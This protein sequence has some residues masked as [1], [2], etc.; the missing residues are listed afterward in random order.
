MGRYV[1]VKERKTLPGQP[2]HWSEKKKAE[3]VVTWLA[4]GSPIETSRLINVPVQT[5]KMWKSQ[6]WWEEMVEDIRNNESQQT[7]N[8]MSKLINKALDMLVERM[9]EGNYQYDQKSGRIV[10]IPMNASDITKV[11]QT[12]FDKR[13]LIRKQPTSIKTSP[14]NTEQKL[15][16][17]AQQFAAFV[18]KSQKQELVS[19]YIEGETVVQ[20]D[21]GV[22]R[23]KEELEHAI[24][25]EREEGLQEGASV[26]TQE[27]TQSC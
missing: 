15:L 17:L 24:H 7:D 14:E 26:G 10:K 21:D 5:V 19:D 8:K 27:E 13:Q 11:T 16:K 18:G 12:L 23:V 22:Y 6:P 2:G 9:E 25:E 1:Y 3:A 20:D 4:T